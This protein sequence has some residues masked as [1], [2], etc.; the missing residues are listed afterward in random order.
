MTGRAV[1]GGLLAAGVL[2]LAAGGSAV[3]SSGTGSPPTSLPVSVTIMSIAPGYLTDSRSVLV[4]GTVTN[5]SQDPLTGLTVQL[6]SSS[7]AISSRDGLQFYENGATV[8]D[9]PVAGADTTIGTTLAPQATVSWSIKLRAKQLKLVS[10]GVYP[11]AA[12]VDNSAGT[13][14]VAERTFL[15]FWP[16]KRALDPARQDISW[17]WPLIG[18]PDQSVCGGLLTNR[19]A[20]SFAS[21]GRLASLLTTGLAYADSAHLTWA[22]EPSMLASAKAMTQPYRYGGNATCGNRHNSPASK[23]AASWLAGLQSVTASQPYFLT[24]YADVDAAA[25]IHR[26]RNADLTRA[27]TVGRSTAQQAL[28]PAPGAAQTGSAPSGD[29]PLDTGL[30]WPAEGIANYSVLIGLAANG[31]NTV[32]LNSSIIPPSPSQTFDPSAVT[33]TPSGVG[34]RMHVL[35][36]DDT[37]SQVL[38]N[39]N[40]RTEPPGTPFAVSQRFLA[41]TAMFAAE[42]PGLARSMVVAPPRAWNPPPGLASQLLASTVSAPWLRPVS[43]PALASAPRGSGQ[44]HHQLRRVTS[45]QE[46]HAGLLRGAKRLD[47]SAGLLESIRTTKNSKLTTAVLAVESSAWRGGGKRAREARSLLRRI[48]A[49]VA[50]QQH[51]LLLIGPQR[52]TLGGLSGTLPVSISNQLPYAVTVRLKVTVPDS[53]PGAQ[54][55]SVDLPTGNVVVPAN[56]DKTLKPRVHADAIGSTTIQLSL[57]SPSGT[58]LPGRTVTLTVQAT[59]FGTLALVIIGGALAVFML[60]SMRRAFT[61]GRG[62]QPSPAADGTGPEPASQEAPGQPEQ[63]DNVVTDRAD[64]PTAEDPDEYA[65]TPSRTD[66]G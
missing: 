15:P 28:S 24:P 41:E 65:S 25:L 27:F 55:I 7:T 37:L 34:P 40:A 49:Y 53:K 17:V 58:P 45:K 60:A 54:R 32:I 35:I 12:E 16:G 63:A 9:A 56:T 31:I 26:G 10:F 47:A 48:S 8:T 30:A 39:A 29:S 38:A 5:T 51:A 66:G 6:R 2:A 23:A 20:A 64:E 18:R 19:L 61:R 36:S 50:S 59:H 44:V 4:R 14:L 11:L 46:L 62:E 13:G 21:G 22:I 3:A 57:E 43:L 42:A 52:V 33:T 1:A